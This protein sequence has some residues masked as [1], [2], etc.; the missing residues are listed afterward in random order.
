MQS[1]SV[2]TDLQRNKSKNVSAVS[3]K[4]L[5]SSAPATSTSIPPSAN[6]K[7]QKLADQ[8]RMAN[9]PSSASISLISPTSPVFTKPKNKSKSLRALIEAAAQAETKINPDK[10][11]K[12]KYAPK[13]NVSKI[14]KAAESPST[15]KNASDS[16]DVN[17]DET[18]SRDNLRVDS[19]GE[20]ENLSANK[21][22]M[23]SRSGQQGR[24]TLQDVKA[25][26]RRAKTTSQT[27]M[28]SIV[29]RIETADDPSSKGQKDVNC[30][31]TAKALSDQ[32]P[33]S[34]SQHSELQSVKKK[35]LLSEQSSLIPLQ[36]DTSPQPNLTSATTPLLSGHLSSRVSQ[37]APLSHTISTSEGLKVGH[38]MTGLLSTSPPPTQISRPH[39]FLLAPPVRGEA[40][41]ADEGLT[42]EKLQLSVRKQNTAHIRAEG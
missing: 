8:I 32:L 34:S 4:Q 26:L 36:H 12:P 30:L 5:Q 16:L 2:T 7:K 22:L 21:L 10:D 15:T 13:N 37:A 3:S 11:P 24:I 41:R 33:S 23:K 1:P 6:K 20:N 14:K 19:E 17:I 25:T 38:H 9:T 27:S 31:V 35:S 18:S 42:K 29:S 39:P 28:L 40:L